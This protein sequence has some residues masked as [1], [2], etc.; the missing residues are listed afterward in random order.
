MKGALVSVLTQIKEQQ[1]AFSI[2]IEP[3]NGKTFFLAAQNPEEAE[4]WRIA[5]YS[6]ANIEKLNKSRNN[7][8]R[9]P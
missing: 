2:Q 9:S 3:P 4:D 7:S 1:H 6:A 8:F 5:I